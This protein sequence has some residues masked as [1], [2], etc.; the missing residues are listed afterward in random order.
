MEVEQVVGELPH[1]F[2]RAPPS[3]IV[4]QGLEECSSVWYEALFSIRELTRLD[5]LPTF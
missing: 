3:T 2:F 4:R 1:F 5:R